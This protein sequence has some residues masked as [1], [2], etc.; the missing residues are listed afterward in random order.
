M[1]QGLIFPAALL[2]VLLCVSCTLHDSIPDSSSAIIQWVDDFDDGIL[3]GWTTIVGGFVIDNYRLTATTGEYNVITHP[4][5][6]IRGF[7]NFTVYYRR[8]QCHAMW[9]IAFVADSLD[10]TNYPENS[11]ELALRW[12]GTGCAT[13]VPAFRLRSRTN[14]IETL[15]D[16][17]AY[18]PSGILDFIYM[19]QIEIVRQ[20]DGYLY[21]W[22]NRTH[23]NPIFLDTHLA[24]MHTNCSYF[25]IAM[26]EQYSIW[27]DNISVDN[28]P[29][30]GPPPG[31]SDIPFPTIPPEVLL[32][33]PWAIG[34]CLV[35]GGLVVW[36]RRQKKVDISPG[37]EL[38]EGEGN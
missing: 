1:K 13:A 27:V 36:R 4:S 2:M 35:V 25:V 24:P 19:V 18:S 26:E 6:V 12:V 31:P 8:A 7:W 22:L 29:D 11:Y 32:V 17:E 37:E 9:A 21:A 5:S 16:G 14:G 23:T 33:T 20:N 34:L 15:H 38:K 10:I 30:N 3:D 28:N